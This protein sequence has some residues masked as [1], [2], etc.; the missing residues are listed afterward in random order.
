M[1]SKRST[2]TFG[3]F[4]AIIAIIS[5]GENNTSEN[6]EFGFKSFQKNNIFQFY[7][8]KCIKQT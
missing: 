4:I 6:N 5:L 2:L 7:P 1:K 3:T 8:F